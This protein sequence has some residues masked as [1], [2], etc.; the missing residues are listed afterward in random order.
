[1][2]R[3][4]AAL[5]VLLGLLASPALAE[6][7]V[8]SKSGFK[9]DQQA[10]LAGQKLQI[11][12]FTATWCP[13][14]KKMKAETWVDEKVESWADANA[15]V[16]PIDID[17]EGA[18]AAQ[19]RVR[20]IPT[21]V[22]LMGDKELGRTV[23]YQAPDAFLGWLDGYRASHLDPARQA[24]GA[25]IK[26]APGA[27]GEGA[28]MIAPAEA[29]SGLSAADALAMY[30]RELRSDAT[31][32]GVTGSLLIPRLAE[33]ANTDADLK[34]KLAERVRTLSENLS[35]QGTAGMQDVREF[36]QLAPVAG[37]REEA[38]AWIDAQLA[39]GGMRDLVEKNALLAADLYAEAGRYAEAQGLVGDPMQH[40]RKLLSAASR[41]GAKS[42]RELDESLAGAFETGQAELIRRELAN[43]VVMALASGEEAKAKAIARLFPGGEA[44]KDQQAIDAAAARAGVE[45]IQIAD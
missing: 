13:P 30:A 10:A 35:K 3:L 28:P 45:P 7:E 4:A 31:G 33:L 22:V 38:L 40:A 17:Q 1:M 9:A 23:G 34:S 12:Y 37:M 36:L 43:A 27:G 5:A 8:F 24:A 26:P 25:P 18:L 32:L 42:L 15:I 11:A 19:Y 20:S 2:K 44:S 6:P 39:E 29:G 16:T 41:A 14:C 21:I